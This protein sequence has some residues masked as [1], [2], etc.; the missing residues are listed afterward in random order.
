MSH[1]NF[2]AIP[3]LSATVEKWIQ[4]RKAYG[5]YVPYVITPIIRENVVA[6]FVVTPGLSGGTMKLT[7][8]SGKQVQ[9]NQN[10]IVVRMDI[11]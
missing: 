11:R 1:Q 3:G 7:L 6:S 2:P 9:V 10:G 5:S 8:S 4:T